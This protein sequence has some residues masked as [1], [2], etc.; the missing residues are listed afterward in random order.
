ML[1]SGVTND[2]LN[3]KLGWI[4]VKGQ[5]QLFTNINQFH[6]SFLTVRPRKK[7]SVERASNGS[8]GSSSRKESTTCTYGATTSFLKEANSFV[9]LPKSETIRMDAFTMSRRNLKALG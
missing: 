4:T 6:T 7:R 1:Q 8:G 3:K 2:E 5:I 9:Y